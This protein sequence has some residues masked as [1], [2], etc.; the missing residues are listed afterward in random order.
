MSTLI[1]FYTKSHTTHNNTK[2]PLKRQAANLVSRIPLRNTYIAV[3]FL[4]FPGNILHTISKSIVE[5]QH[6]SMGNKNRDT[7]ITIISL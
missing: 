7:S 3:I 5:L 4:F 2:Y 1:S 6:R